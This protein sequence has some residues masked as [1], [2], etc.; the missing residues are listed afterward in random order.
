MGFQ[1]REDQK[2]FLNFESI[3]LCKKKVAACV[4][5]ACITYTGHK[6]KPEIFI[7][8]LHCAMLTLETRNV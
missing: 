3:L 8:Q 5:Y 7:T 2:L 4:G 1:V 6:A